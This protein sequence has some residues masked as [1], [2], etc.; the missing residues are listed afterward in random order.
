VPPVDDPGRD[1]MIPLTL[2][3]EASASILGYEPEVLLH[4]L[5][6]GEIRGIKLDGQWRMSVF[7]LAEILGTSVESLL[8][9]LEDYFLAEKIEEVRDDE[10][11][12]PEEGR[13][14]YESFLKEAP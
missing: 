9:F 14:V 7:V 10:F 3:L 12:E 11:F 13:K 8:E 1:E 6:R 2:D 4:S 5:E